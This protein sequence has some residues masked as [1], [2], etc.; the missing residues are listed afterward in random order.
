MLALVMT[1]V[2]KMRRTGVR[3]QLCLIAAVLVLA[4]CSSIKV[5]MEPDIPAADA[6]PDPSVSENLTQADAVMSCDSIATERAGIKTSLADL[7][8]SPAAAQLRQRDAELVS[9]AKLK[10]C[11]P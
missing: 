11:P 4:G 8:G 6:G 9:L 3:R 10:R 1:R 7:D 2:C 5:P